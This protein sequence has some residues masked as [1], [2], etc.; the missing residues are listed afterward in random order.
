M[1]IYIYKGLYVWVLVRS[2]W[3]S[4]P[5]ALGLLAVHPPDPCMF[6]TEHLRSTEPKEQHTDRDSTFDYE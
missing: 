3:G 4:F 2:S 5:A 1:Y 6:Q